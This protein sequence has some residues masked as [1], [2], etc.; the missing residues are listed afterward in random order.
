MVI[1]QVGAPLP[2]RREERRSTSPSS[3]TSPTS[4]SFIEQRRPEGRAAAG[5]AARARWCRSTRSRSWCSRRRRST[6]CRCRPTSSEPGR[7]A[8]MLTPE[9]FGLDARP[10]AGRRHRA[11][12]AT[13]DTGRHR[14]RARG[15][16]AAVGRHR[17]PARRLRRH[18]RDGGA[19]AEATPRRP[20]PSSSRCCSAARTT[21]TTTTRTSRRFL[22][23]GGKI[24]L[25]H[26]P[27]LYGAYLLEPVP[28]ARRA[29][30]R[31]SS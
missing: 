9:S 25:Q 4:H 3:A 18:R 27:L 14:H 12:A 29:G 21:C 30:A 7:Q 15:R 5:A 20:T 19:Q 28:R 22:D 13:I 26:D 31:C 1:A 16:A 10:A 23:N 8:A 24:G 6:A 11:R 2:D 17:Q